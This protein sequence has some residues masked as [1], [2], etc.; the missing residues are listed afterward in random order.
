MNAAYGFPK[1]SFLFQK[2]FWKLDPETK[3]GVN[4]SLGL[5]D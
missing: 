2:L 5:N 3:G 1:L 4:I